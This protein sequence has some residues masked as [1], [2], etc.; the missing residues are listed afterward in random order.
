MQKGGAASQITHYKKWFL[1]RLCFVPG[2]ENVIQKKQNQ[3][4]SDPSGPNS[5]KEEQEILSVCG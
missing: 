4:T 5:I 2:E 3:W 1:D